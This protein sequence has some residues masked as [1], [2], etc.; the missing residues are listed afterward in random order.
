MKSDPQKHHR[1]SIR[2]KG[3]D[4]TQPGAYFIT[5]VSHNR[6][7]IFGE[8]VD[9]EMRLN[10][11]GCIT[12]REWERLPRRFPNIHLDAFIVMPNHI[13]GII[14][15]NDDY[16]TGT[17]PN[18]VTK[19]LESLRRAPTTHN[20]IIMESESPRHAPTREQFGKPVPRSIPTIMRSYKSAVTQSINIHRLSPGLPVWQRNY[21]E[22]IVRDEVELTRI[23][24][25]IFDNP[26][27][28][29]IDRENLAFLFSEKQ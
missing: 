14:I 3:Y 21:Y 18:R 27:R 20:R 12:Q 16:R 13:H 4:Y 24:Q 11:Y 8:I 5:V 1:H 15:I 10:R 25:Y 6:E 28:W 29:E 9:G 23:R 2:L 7:S 19:E 17:A 26:L 22:H